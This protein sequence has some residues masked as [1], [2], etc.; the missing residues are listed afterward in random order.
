MVAK[1]I[2]KKTVAKKPTKKLIKK[3]AF[4]KVS[5]KPVAMRSFHVSHLA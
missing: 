5:K 3:T 2:V 4:K 1:N